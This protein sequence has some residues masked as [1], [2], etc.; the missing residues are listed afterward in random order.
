M[1]AL[2]VASYI[3]A[4]GES[5]RLVRSLKYDKQLV[6]SINAASHTPSYVDGAFIV[7]AATQPETW[8]EASKE[9]TKEVYRLQDELVGEKELAKAKKQK[10]AELIFG[11]QTVQDAA[12]NLAWNYQGT[13]D[14]LFDNTYVANIQKVTAEQ[15]RDVA[16][17]YF[18]PGRLNRIVISPPGG[19][20]KVDDEM[21]DNKESEVHAVKLPNGVRLLGQAST[22]SATG[23]YP[24]V[25]PGCQSG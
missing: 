10:A 23:E 25:H 22:E 3:L 20:P 9:I 8:E 4:H 11:R 14:P 6:L 13:A 24:S 16:R 12:E 21:A 7:M 1:Y 2:D 5:S 18:V 19:A 15:V 17:R